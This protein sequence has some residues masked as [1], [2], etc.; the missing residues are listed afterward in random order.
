MDNIGMDTQ[1]IDDP[2]NRI[3]AVKQEV[4]SQPTEDPSDADH[5]I[6]DSLRI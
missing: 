5:D 6:S 1:R 2:N 4:T 3:Q